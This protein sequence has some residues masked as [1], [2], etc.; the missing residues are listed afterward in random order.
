MSYQIT[1]PTYTPIATAM[2]PTFKQHAR[3]DFDDD[4]LLITKHLI[5]S[6][7]I[8]EAV[9]GFRVAGATVT[10]LPE[11][12]DAFGSMASSYPFPVLPV[13][14]W[15]VADKDGVDITNQFQLVQSAITDPA[16]LQ[17][18]DGSAFPVGV[19]VTYL[20]GFTDGAGMP[21]NLESAIYRVAAHIYENRESITSISLETVPLWL[22]DLLVGLWV[23]RA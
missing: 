8:V 21:P 20:T 1:N 2:L 13:G 5:W 18:K 23:P 16:F 19:V 22:N 14:T 15:T 11:T 7:S 9:V 17:T 4:D 3:I 10:W 6:C 12:T